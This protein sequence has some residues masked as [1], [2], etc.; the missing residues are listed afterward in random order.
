MTL[1]VTEHSVAGWQA[2]KEAASFV[3]DPMILRAGEVFANGA[4]GA[5]A[6]GVADMEVMAALRDNIGGLIEFFDLVVAYD[7]VPLIDY[8]YTFDPD[9]VPVQ[10]AALLGDKALPVTIGY[11]AYE[12]IKRG[13]LQSLAATD[14]SRIA[15]FGHQLAELNALRYQWKPSLEGGTRE[16][17][18]AQSASLDPPT[19]LAAEFLLGGLIFSGFAQASWLDHIIQPKRSRFYLALT[20][21]PAT[22]GGVTHEEEEAVFAAAEQGLHGTTASARRL[23]SLP[24]VLPYLLAKAPGT[25]TAADL[26]KRALDFANTKDGDN[27]R[28]A[29]ALIRGDGLQAAKT[30]DSAKAARVQAQA[31]LAPFSK[32]AGRE[33]GLKVEASAGS[34][35]LKLSASKTLY[36]PGWLSSWWN[37]H[38]PFGGLRKTFRRMWLAA[39]SY[40]A[41]ERRLIEA[42]AQS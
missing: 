33:G 6:L 25:V 34:D 39:E 13:A 42:W 28:K 3:P 20:A 24:P 4:K 27:Y 15:K 11:Q 9:S 35:G 14:L 36:A 41:L 7:Q 18:L 1:H 22:A 5:K 38:T 31:L 8:Q 40:E 19:R 17:W 26:L 10:I 29:A 21:T 32:L 37:E 23:D 12:S 16:G 2:F 30:A